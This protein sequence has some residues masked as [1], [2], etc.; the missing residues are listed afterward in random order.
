MAL[1][2]CEF[3]IRDDRQYYKENKFPLELSEYLIPHYGKI[4]FHITDF[5]PCRYFVW[6]TAYYNN[7]KTPNTLK[8]T[9]YKDVKLIEM[10]M[11]E[12]GHHFLKYPLSIDTHPFVKDSVVRSVLMSPLTYYRSDVIGNNFEHIFSWHQKTEIKK[13]LGVTDDV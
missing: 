10:G 4:I 2:K 9:A 13:I 8:I 11:N 1:K 6:I 12:S 7:E 3:L 5:K